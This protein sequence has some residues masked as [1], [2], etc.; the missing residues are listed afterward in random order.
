MSAGPFS[1]P[2]FAKINLYLEI[3]GKREDGYHELVTLYQTVSLWDT[4]TFEPG[5]DVVVE[6]SDNDVP[7]GQGNIVHTAA[8]ALKARYGIVDGARVR[9]EKR[10]PAPGGLG[11]GSSNAAA[12]LVG[13]TRLW[14]IEV[15]RGELLAIAAHLGSDV[16]FFLHGGTAIG[17]GRGE[18]IEEC[19]DF[20]GL[21]MVI[22]TPAVAVPTAASYA[23]LNAPRLTTTASNILQIC[24]PDAGD[25]GFSLA[26]MRN[27]LEAAVF[28]MFPEVERVK[29]TLLSLGAQHAMMCGSGASVFGIFDK[30]ETRQAALKALDNEV[31]WRKFA[32]AT[33]SREDYREALSMV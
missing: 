25:P 4:L 7:S 29:R 28:G 17:R 2:S 15:P 23:A 32:V 3:L 20:P 19:S 33:V 11:G 16:P 12:A 5:K 10:I 13:L 21:S 8:T 22:V 6:C 24:R 27:D 14:G 18:A 9:I 31:N 1:L 26:A 30:E